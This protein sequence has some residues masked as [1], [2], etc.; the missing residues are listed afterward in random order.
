MWK[1]RAALLCIVGCHC[2]KHLNSGLTLA[3]GTVRWTYDTTSV[4]CSS[5]GGHIFEENVCAYITAD[6]W[7]AHATRARVPTRWSA[8]VIF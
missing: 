8:N 2:L 5:D 4:M 7:H 3:R 6:A 1:E